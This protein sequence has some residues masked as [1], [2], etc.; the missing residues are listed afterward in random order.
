METYYYKK[1]TGV[2]ITLQP[3]GEMILQDLNK[4]RS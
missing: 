1:E 4:P 2:V 3:H